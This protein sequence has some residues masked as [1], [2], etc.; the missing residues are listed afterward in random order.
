MAS[1]KPS[2]RTGETR[3]PVGG[4]APSTPA[5]VDGFLKQLAAT[6][7][8]RPADGRGR[9]AFALDATASRQPT[10]NLARE[11]QADMFAAAA[12][13]GGLEMQIVYYRGMG[14]CRASPFVSDAAT[15]RRLMNGISCEGGLTQMH[16]ILTHL[17][18]EAERSG[19]KAAVFVG[20]ALEEDADA[21]HAL[22]GQLALRGVRLF[23]FQEGYDT[24]VEATFRALAKLTGGAYCRFDPQAGA[25]LRALLSAVAAYAAGGRT[26]LAARRDQG[27][28]RLLAALGG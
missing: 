16:R 27:A 3:L 28:M 8:A 5:E 10:W 14:E 26:A 4:A 9:L 12:A 17:V 22:A 15:L 2:T 18:A 23:L 20:D 24:T 6:P 21:L 1:D 25:Q 13:L 7:S 11:I 19:V